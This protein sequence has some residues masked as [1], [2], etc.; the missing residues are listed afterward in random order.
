MAMSQV[1]CSACGLSIDV[2][3]DDDSE[4]LDIFGD[5]LDIYNDTIKAI[6][7]KKVEPD[8]RYEYNTWDPPASTTLFCK[9]AG[10]PY[11][12]LRSRMASGQGPDE[13]TAV[14]TRLDTHRYKCKICVHYEVDS[15][16]CQ[17]KKKTANPEAI[18]KGFE[19]DLQF[20]C[21]GLGQV[22]LFVV[23]SSVLYTP[24]WIFTRARNPGSRTQFRR[25]G[26]DTRGERRSGGLARGP[27]E[28]LAGSGISCN[29][30]E[31]EERTVQITVYGGA[32]EIGGNKV[33]VEYRWNPDH[34]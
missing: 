26:I 8:A 13:V 11:Q 14:R 27:A 24:G 29:T 6:K 22:P 25:E 15:A 3:A 20:R 23:K 21:E 5:F 33:L 10:V 19:P 18:C 2:H 4:K 34:A 7:E 12:A 30:N 1:T 31:R 32:G 17:L 9:M 28:K 16:F